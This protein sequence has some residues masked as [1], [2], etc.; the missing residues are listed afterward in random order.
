MEKYLFAPI[1]C[2]ETLSKIHK[3]KV[4]K[5]GNEDEGN[6]VFLKY[7]IYC[8]LFRHSVFGCVVFGEKKS[9]FHKVIFVVKLSAC[10]C[11]TKIA[12]VFLCVL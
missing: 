9:V 6:T 2:R 11:Y 8:H 7:Q 1:K 4:E 5:H 12:I 10:I 3:L